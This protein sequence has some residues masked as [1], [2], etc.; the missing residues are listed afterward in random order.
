MSNQVHSFPTFHPPL[1]DDGGRD[2]IHQGLVATGHLADAALKHGVVSH[3]AGVAFVPPGDRNL[4][5]EA[6][7]LG[8]E[9]F[10]ILQVVTFAPVGLHGSAH[11]KT[12]N[13]LT[14]DIVL[15][16]GQQLARIH[17]GQAIGDNLQRV[18][19]SQTCTTDPVV[20]SK[21]SAHLGKRMFAGEWIPYFL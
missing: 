13:W 11:N 19:H 15:N 18:R 10:N 7:Q 20:Y 14:P 1:Q 3:D 4:R 2:F 12:L 8:N 5:K 9:A 17:R 21:N 16:V 6:L